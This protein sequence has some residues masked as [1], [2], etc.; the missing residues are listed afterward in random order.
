MKLKKEEI[1]QLLK[2][3]IE[4]SKKKIIVLDDDPT[5]VQT[6]HGVSVYTN[7]SKESIICGLKELNR[8]FFILTN[9][10]G[11]TEEQTIEVHRE[12]AKN[13]QL[14]A[15]KLGISY[16]L[17]SRSDST[18]RGHYPVETQVIKEQIEICQGEKMDGEILCP[19]FEEG[20]RI[21]KKDIHY[22]Q[23]NDVWIPVSETEFAKDKTF[24]Y[25]NSDL[26]LYI[27]EK[28]GGKYKATDVI[29]VSLESIRCL[30]I[31]GIV[32]QLMQVQNFNKVIVNA[33]KYED[34]NIFCIALYLA[35][36]KGKTFLF[37]TAAS[38][39]RVVSGIE[40]RGLLTYDE[41]ID[42]KTDRGGIVIIGSYTEK[43]TLQLQALQTLNGLEF[44]EFNSDL[45]MNE[46]EFENEVK[47]VLL[48]E[49]N[50]ILKGKTV[51]VYTK[52]KLLSLE[53]DTK[54]DA[55]I[56]S[57]K[58]S[59]AL[60]SLIGQLA[61]TPRFVIAKGGITSSDIGTKALHVKKALVLGQIKP[62]IPV[63]QLGEES[64]F[65][66]IPY[67][68]FPGNVGEVETLKEVLEIL[69]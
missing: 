40:K 59:N 15:N 68:I 35:M 26:K 45:V 13:I 53:Q 44:I 46:K 28:T 62:G 66:L 69:L 52:R 50:F 4:K 3:E 67:V 1:E 57:V 37:R 58:I 16:L 19:F 34:L 48:L 7:W 2:E 21:T 54:E 27:E 51:V 41:L 39:V 42:K 63:W 56:R 31:K 12:I 38:F 11:F 43:T 55:L 8:V 10:R 65:P 6:V 32:A 9:S 47:R 36:A 23:Y 25:K 5:G 29:S 49:E 18:L 20:K 64:K 33:E 61:I 17:I 60:Q 22:V 14:E 30:D 24:G